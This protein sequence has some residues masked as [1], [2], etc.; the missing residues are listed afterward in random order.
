MYRRRTQAARTSTGHP[1]RVR[2]ARYRGSDK[3][4]GRIFLGVHV[5][6][7][8]RTDTLLVGLAELLRT[9]PD[10]PFT[11]DIVAVPTPGIERFISQGLGLRL[12]TSPGL[13]DGVCANVL[14]PSPS[15]VIDGVIA[16]TSGI[17]RDADPWLAQ[18]LVWP[19]L[20]VIDDALDEPWCEAPRRYL[21]GTRADRRFALASRL[22]GL[23]T[24]YS[25]QRPD[26]LLAWAAG[27][28]DV[29]SDLAW[30]PQMWR[31]L[32][33]QI[34]TPSPA[35]R[36]HS[37]CAA[38]TEGPHLI[39]L[40]QRLSIF[41]TSR[42]P[43]KHLQVLGALGVH[44]DVHLWLADA[45][46][47]SWNQLPPPPKTRR[48]ADTSVS[49]VVHPLLRSLGRDARELRMR[50]SF[51][52]DE[53][54]PAPLSATSLLG[55][56]QHQ[57]R[58]NTAP[59]PASLE[60]A[61]RSITVHA[62]HGQPRQAEV[63]REVVLGLLESDPTLQA[64]DILVMCPDLDAFAP[65][66]SAAFT[67]ADTT[68]SLRVRIADRTPE[69]SNEVLAALAALLDLVTGRAELSAL[70]DFA[71]REPV[72]MKFT[73]DEDA[74][75]RLEVLTAQAGIRWGLDA[76][77]RCDYQL[78]VSTGTWSWGLDRLLLGAALSE[79]GLPLLAGVL[80]VDDVQSADIA[81]VGRLAELVNR[82][83]QVRTTLR[84]RHPIEAW[85]RIL[86]DIV[87][88]F[89][90]VVGPD[91]WQ[92]P[93][94]LG[95]LAGLT[96]T[97]G[98]YATTVTLSLADIRWL[99]RALLTGR[100]TRSNFRSG[101]LTV[102]GLAPMR[103]VPHRV[104]CLVGMDDAVFPRSL[105][106]DG[107]DA[108]A[109]DPH[110]GERDVHSEDRQVL[111]DAIMAAVDHLVITYTGADDRTNQPRPPCV[112]LSDLLDTLDT[113]TH[114]AAREQLRI[115]HPLQP[116]DARNF[117]GG[118]LGQPGPFSHDVGA[119]AAAR[120]AVRPR[121]PAPS[122]LVTQIA[123]VTITDLSPRELG[124][125][126]CSPI[127]TFV[128]SRLGISLRGEDDPPPEQ[129]PI[130]LDGLGRWQVG[131]RA[132]RL[133]NR[134]E[135]VAAV[136]AAERARGQL[137]PGALGVEVLTEVGRDAS[138]VASRYAALRSGD[139]RQV[140]VDI[141][142]GNGV[143]IVGAVP[144]V[145]GQHLV[146]A[147]FSKSKP[148]DE[149]R[150]WPDLLALAVTD[151]QSRWQAHMV[152]KNGGVT[153]TAPP[154]PEALE[155]LVSLID[156]YRAGLRSPLPL[157][158]ATSHSYAQRRARGSSPSA[159]VRAAQFQHWQPT[160][161]ADRDAPEIVA[162]WGAEAGIDVLLRE[163][164]GAD[165]N[166]FDEDTRFAMLARRVWA[167]IIAARETS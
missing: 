32:R 87:D 85:R 100:P 10:D 136:A 126:L 77:H 19:L 67:A 119:L 40:P 105:T 44:R 52:T 101:D 128:R 88:D 102:C 156:L 163:P 165:E 70:L 125:F 160:Y 20:A 91:A 50:L 117:T 9:I 84:G 51:D 149:L 29:S 71:G 134:G 111:L 8:E 167:P 153:L 110:L 24:S 132:L 56:L 122:L 83:Q 144:D 63:I 5:H 53:Y 22:A 75:E 80:P 60:P 61:D 139:P 130:A 141:D 152:T 48:R 155:I 26:L 109:R 73:F 103:S 162:L 72:S 28:D 14:F 1:K 27:H 69:Q 62:C 108:L 34:G 107:D 99:L 129:I 147:T 164:P 37:A 38:I 21:A 46:P 66:L 133:L 68:A 135:P 2:G 159:A 59:L 154:A 36:L 35:E 89:M 113:M 39:D 6:R 118:T 98:P 54:L 94:A 114:G 76:E 120:Q 140:G 42:L 131:E 58:D 55:R 138:G 43:S 64:R 166:W 146:R 97:A 121:H 7:S 57:I 161:G 148:R 112:P 78:Q 115:T 45:S 3:E 18:R 86:A 81:L 145:Y 74:L 13:T 92:V 158:A 104:I 95:A 137:P 127:A 150:L 157:P 25:A 106:P 151:P 17:T 90:H 30:Q 41:G 11:P 33:E 47:A 12:G 124:T 23:F 82:L 49:T 31:R 79:E 123:D 65:L 15:A 93:N 4:S 142:T 143:R 96:D 116:F 16:Q